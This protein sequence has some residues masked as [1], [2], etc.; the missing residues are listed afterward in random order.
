MPD[1]QFYPEDSGGG[2]FLFVEDNAR[3]M[4]DDTY[5]LDA[6]VEKL[7]YDL[8]RQNVGEDSSE[9]AARAFAMDALILAREAYGLDGLGSLG[10]TEELVSRVDSMKRRVA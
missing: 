5:L 2:M 7:V 1:V 8:Q 3:I 10:E 9:E 6:V 4:I